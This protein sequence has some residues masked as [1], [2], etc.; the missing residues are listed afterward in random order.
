MT[1]QHQK[2]VT[3]FEAGKL[4]D[5][6]IDSFL[7]ELDSLNTLHEGETQTYFQHA[8]TLRQ[9]IRF[10]RRNPLL[11][12]DPNSDSSEGGA[13][14]VQ[15]GAGLDLLRCESVNA[16]D[17]ATCGRVLK[18]NYSLLISMSPLARETRTVMSCIPPHVGPAIPE[19]SS[20]W[21]KLWLY[22][23]I[24]SGPPS[25][26]FKAGSRVRVVPQLFHGYHDLLVMSSVGGL[27]CS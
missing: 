12:L 3:M 23:K 22:H 14:Q 26:L 10:L 4:S 25:I 5:E 15:V 7:E 27:F 9:T 19:L 21:F 20:M 17:A 13:E 1:S 16:L 18:K 8:V 6:L 11:P 2:A 24:G